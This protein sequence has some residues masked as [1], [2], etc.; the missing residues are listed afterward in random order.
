MFFLQL[1][2]NVVGCLDHGRPH[3]IRHC[4]GFLVERATTHHLK[5]YDLERYWTFKYNTGKR[6][7]QGNEQKVGLT[8]EV[9]CPM[10]S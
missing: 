7:S 6:F 2:K 4:T 1:T 10:C 5:G 8:D 3:W 9:D